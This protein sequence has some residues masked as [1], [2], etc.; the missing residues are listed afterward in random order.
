MPIGDVSMAKKPLLS[1]CIPTYNR[2][3][4]FDDALRVLVEQVN[5]HNS[6]DVEFVISDNASTDDTLSVVK[7][8]RQAYPQI[9]LVYSRHKS[10]IPRAENYLTATNLA[11][12][13]FVYLLSDDDIILPGAIAK[14][15][16]EIKNNQGIDA[17]APNTHIFSEIP[18]EGWSVAYNVEEDQLIYD[19]NEIIVC[20]GMMLTHISCLVFRKRLIANKSY[21][22]RIGSDLTNSYMFL[23]ILQNESGCL[24]LK[25][26][27]LGMRENNSLEY[28]FLEVFITNFYNLLKHAESKGYSKFATHELLSTDLKFVANAVYYYKKQGTNKQSIPSLP[29]CLWRLLPLFPIHP[30][31]TLRVLKN[32]IFPPISFRDLLNL[33]SRSYLF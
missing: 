15:I 11:K 21:L 2:A 9:Q 33:P 22:E 29:E 4:L 10:T 3:K 12:G 25:T 17:I 31:D 19:K 28:N 32:L 20:L 27:Y 5:D 18:S 6:F 7:R 23:D 24:I 14:I 1:V 13:E 30:I 8:I 26:P 16:M